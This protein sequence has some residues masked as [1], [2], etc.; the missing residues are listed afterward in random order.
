VR[1][2][3]EVRAAGA[4]DRAAVIELAVRALGWTGDERDLAFF[5]WKHDANPFGA[6]PSWVATLDGEVVAFRTFMRWE[7]ARGG[8]TLRMVRAVDTATDPAHQ[9]KGLFRRLTEQSIDALRSTGTGAVF[10]TPNAQSRP[11]Y[12]KMGW[13]EVGRPTVWVHPRGLGD[14][15]RMAR[16]RQ[17]AAKWSD[18][19]T[20]G[21]PAAAVAGQLVT[22]PSEPA[23][24]WAT[25]RTSRY[26]Q[27]RYS[28]APLCYRVAEVRGGAC[29]FRVRRRGDAREVAICE[30][31]SPRS[32]PRSLRK[33]VRSAGDYA[34][35]LGAHVRQG[36]VP[37][38][39]RG[40]TVTWRDLGDA[41]S[42]PLAALGLRLGDIELF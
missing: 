34:I 17:P 33:I 19:V 26:L 3:Y 14:V 13:V 12:L 36:M 7:L 40:P 4:D 10:N 25:P 1:D 9:G 24:R 11:G 29:V 28:F 20:V 18:D 42:P 38:P 39:G 32:D 37:L 35:A 41:P 21:E 5:G 2:R 27:W 22:G 8:T 16:S 30:W 15:V 6:S 23:D 31:L